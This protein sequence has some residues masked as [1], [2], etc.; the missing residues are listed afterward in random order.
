MTPL[1]LTPTQLER[2]VLE[3]ILTSTVRRA[4]GL[5]ELCGFGPVAAA[6]RTMQLIAMHQPTHVILV[7]IAGS[8]R[9]ELEVGAARSFRQVRCDG[10]GA[11]T[12]AD[13][14]SASAIGWKHWEP[15]DSVGEEPQAGIGDVIPL[16]PSLTDAREL[17]GE[18]LTVCAASANELDVVMRWK[19]YPDAVAEDME[20][21]GVA[22]ACF[23][24]G[25][26]LQIIRGISNRA[27][28]RDQ[29][30]WNFDGAIHAAGQLTLKALATLTK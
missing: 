29:R 19:R 25:V 10:I 8:L 20:G 26:P 3:A 30:N 12:G 17:G 11:G 13:H 15:A 5:Q 6:A 14:R 28:D 21:F 4:N 22:A 7:G 16:A 9:P 18:L 1:V 23:F 24:G 2:R 27:G